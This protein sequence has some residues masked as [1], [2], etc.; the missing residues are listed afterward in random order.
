MSVICNIKL[1][2]MEITLHLTSHCPLASPESIGRITVQWTWPSR[3]TRNRI[4]REKSYPFG[5]IIHNKVQTANGRRVANDSCTDEI[6]MQY[7]SF[8]QPGCVEQKREWRCWFRRDSHH[9]LP[10]AGCFQTPL[11]KGHWVHSPVLHYPLGERI[12]EL[13]WSVL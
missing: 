3:G 12:I 9:R 5:F 2:R 6:A 11:L 7:K 13:A 10:L 8:N 4:D 1:G